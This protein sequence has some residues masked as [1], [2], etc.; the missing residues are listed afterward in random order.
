M[1]KMYG[2]QYTTG[3]DQCPKWYKDSFAK[4][5]DKE[6]KSQIISTAIKNCFILDGAEV[7]LY[8]TL[9]KTIII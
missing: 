2:L 4:H 7:P 1:K 8:P 3:D 9:V 5:Q 6:D